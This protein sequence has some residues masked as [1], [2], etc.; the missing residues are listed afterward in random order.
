[1]EEECEEVSPVVGIRIVMR[2]VLLWGRDSMEASLVVGR[3]IVRRLVLWW[4]E[5]L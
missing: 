2:I 5:G 1:M 3:R 4:G